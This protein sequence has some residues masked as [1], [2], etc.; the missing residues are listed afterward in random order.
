MKIIDG[1]KIAKEIKKQVKN[2]VQ[3]EFIDRNKQVPCLAC[4]IVEGIVQVKFMLL[5][6]K[7]LRNL[8]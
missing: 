6:K 8:A 2:E 7:R 5:Q 1:K 4:I 3:T